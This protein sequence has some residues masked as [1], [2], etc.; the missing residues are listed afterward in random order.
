MV[1]GIGKELRSMKT[2]EFK[3]DNCS[4]KNIEIDWAK[5]TFRCRHC[6]TLYAFHEDN[7]GVFN[8]YIVPDF[9]IRKNKKGRSYTEKLRKAYLILNSSADYEKAKRL[10]TRI[11]YKKPLDYLGWWGLV[12]SENCNLNHEEAY[13]S[14][15]DPFEYDDKSYKKAIDL[16][17]ASV[18]EKLVRMWKHYL[19]D[20]TAFVDTITIEEL[21]LQRK[22]LKESIHS[23]VQQKQELYTKKRQL[24][25]SYLSLFFISFIVV[26]LISSHFVWAAIV[27]VVLIVCFLAVFL[28]FGGICDY[29]RTSHDDELNEICETIRRK[30][31]SYSE[32]SGQIK[33]I[34]DQITQIKAMEESYDPLEFDEFRE[35]E[36]QEL[37]SEYEEKARGYDN[38][39]SE[40]K[41]EH[42]HTPSGRKRSGGC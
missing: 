28:D 23:L 21:T 12:K 27:S 18:K 15:L 25:L 32:I 6:D 24:I 3:C 37:E 11:L 4:S 16:A 40:R 19:H 30:R 26:L 17:P 2:F 29:I 39:F 36:L 35:I 8:Y 22:E 1:I 34:S 5:R 41:E 9:F 42:G 33:E 14:G 20:Y 7:A 13:R 31:K 10:F 38:A